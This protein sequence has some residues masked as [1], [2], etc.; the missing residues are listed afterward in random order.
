[1]LLHSGHAGLQAE[2]L[3]ILARDNHAVGR[4]QEAYGFYRQVGASGPARGP[5]SGTLSLLDFFAN[6][7][8]SFPLQPVFS[9]TDVLPL[10][11]GSQP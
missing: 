7:P 10:S 5:T 1:M 8:K 11:P 6:T 2:V 9:L 3:T 4:M